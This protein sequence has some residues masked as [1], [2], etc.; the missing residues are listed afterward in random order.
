[1][2]IFSKLKQKQLFILLFTFFLIQCESE[3]GANESFKEQILSPLVKLHV[4]DQS[5]DVVDVHISKSFN[6]KIISGFIS[7]KPTFE[8][9]KIKA[10]SLSYAFEVILLPEPSLGDSIFGIVN[11]SVTP[12]RERPSHVSQ[13]VDQAIMGHPLKLLRQEGDWYLCKT[14]YNYVGWINKTA[15]KRC[16]DTFYHQWEF[17][18]KH[19][20]KKLNTMVYSEPKTFSEPISDLVLNNKII[21]KQRILKWCKVQLPDGRIG[22]IHTSDIEKIKPSKAL[23]MENIVSDA[24]R[25]MGVPYLWGGNSTK[26]NDCSGFT[27]NVFY[28][29]GFQLPRD[30]RQQALIGK[31][32]S[33][34][35]AKPG[36]LFFFG[37]GEKVKHVGICIGGMEFIHQGGKVDIHSLD[38]NS[39][40]F[41]Q[42]RADTFLF[43][44]RIEQN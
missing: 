44:K 23:N 6:E 12:L 35:E 27:Q 18:A 40:R 28:A 33:I 8:A 10:D 41:N 21:V 17:L 36:D 2:S 1:M 26:G 16:D 7:N 24:K 11:V 38:P 9:L 43:V 42:Y 31:D 5:L 29:Q 30:A 4:P 22:F 3:K 15:L 25:M 32:V 14:H 19:R 13:M 20:I 37:E 39:S 34:Y